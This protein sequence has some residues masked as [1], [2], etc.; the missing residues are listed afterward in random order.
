MTDSSLN[1]LVPGGAAAQRAAAGILLVDDHDLVR[2]GFRALVQSQ[3]EFPAAALTVFEARTLAEAL[4]VYQAQQQVIGL[5]VLDL[6]L[7]DTHGLSGL[8]DFRTRFP[9]ATVVVLS[10][11]GSAALKQGALAL[12][13]QAFLA[14]SGD[15]SEVARFVH[16][17]A[18]HGPE[19]AGRHLAANEPPAASL[20]MAETLSAR[21]LQILQWLLEGKSNKEIAQ[22]GFLTE[23]TVKNH[24]STLLLQF[25]A[26]SRAQLISSL[27]T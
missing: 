18:Q 5:V 24:V 22:L 3:A 6:G 21:Q 4:S 11:T 10:G 20:S 27:R 2:F 16:A 8:A 17:C 25:G 19:V 7:P 23:G 15:L 26:R 1:P 9:A 14:K 12:G 13:A